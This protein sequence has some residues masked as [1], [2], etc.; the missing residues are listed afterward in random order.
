M[1]PFVTGLSESDVHPDPLEQF[2]LWHADA[3]SPPEVAV[4]TASPDGIPSVRMVLLKSAD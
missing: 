2:L 4:A 1:I 3:G